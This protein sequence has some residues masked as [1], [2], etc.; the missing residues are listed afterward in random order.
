MKAKEI[1]VNSE[2][3]LPELARS[4]LEFAE[5][6]KVFALY[7]QMGAGKTTLIKELCRQLGSSDNFSSPTY[8][9]A[10]EYQTTDG[11]KIYHLDL[12]R[13]NNLEEAHSIGIEDYIGGN[14][15]C[16][17]EWPELIE[18]LLPVSTIKLEIKADEAI[19]HISLRKDG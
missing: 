6:R 10:N 3:E 9:I 14:N 13:L 7:A 18:T 12:Y 8:S 19:R 2:T 17:V 16:F 15:Y 4:I 11:R 5:N 1:S